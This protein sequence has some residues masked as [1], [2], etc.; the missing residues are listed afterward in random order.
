MLEI[1]PASGFLTFYMESQ[2]A[3]VVAVELGPEADWDIVPHAQLDLAA[4]REERR[5]IMGQLRNGF[6]WTHERLHS[7]AKVHYGDV[8]DL[9]QELGEFD[10][11]VMAAV[12]RHTRDPLRIIEGCARHAQ[13]LVITE[14]QT[15]GLE[16]A[17]VAALVPTREP[18]VWDTWWDFS[19]DLLSRFVELLGFDQ[20]VTSHH[21]QR[22]I[23]GGS[24]HEIPFFTL[25]AARSGSSSGSA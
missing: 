4:I 5:E 10:V 19:P 22:F 13:S 24:E 15:S 25:V 7:Q 12:L 1:G 14:M 18:Q 11:A 2:G 23:S 8:Y 17:P 3:D 6:W 20:L 9:P 16:G 21:S